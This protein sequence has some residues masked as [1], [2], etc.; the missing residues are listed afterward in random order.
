MRRFSSVHSDWMKV[1]ILSTIPMEPFGTGKIAS[2]KIAKLIFE[3]FN[4][5]PGFIIPV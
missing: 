3:H 4:L 2:K 1:L 5:R